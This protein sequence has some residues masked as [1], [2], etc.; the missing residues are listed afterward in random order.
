MDVPRIVS[1]WPFLNAVRSPLHVSFVQCSHDFA[2]RVDASSQHVKAL[3]GGSKKEH[4]SADAR[5]SSQPVH[6]MFLTGVIYP[7]AIASL[8]ELLCV[9]SKGIQ[10]MHKG[11]GFGVGA[12][13]GGGEG[14]RG[15]SAS[16]VENVN[17]S[18][19][20]TA[21]TGESHNLRNS[22][23]NNNNSN[24]KNSDTKNSNGNSSSS[25]AKSFSLK[26]F[27]RLDDSF[28]HSR[29]RSRIPGDASLEE[30]IGTKIGTGTKGQSDDASIVTALQPDDAHEPK[31][32]MIP[33]TFTSTLVDFSSSSRGAS[34][35]KGGLGT[36]SSRAQ[37]E[38]GAGRDRGDGDL[39]D[40]LE[41]SASKRI[42]GHPYFIVRASSSPK[43][44]SFCYYSA[45]PPS[46]SSS[47]STPLGAR[48]RNGSNVCGGVAIGDDTN[49]TAAAA[50]SRSA[51][52]R[53]NGSTHTAAPETETETLSAHSHYTE[54]RWSQSIAV[55]TPIV[56]QI[57]EK[58]SVVG[59]D[60]SGRK[61]KRPVPVVPS[62]HVE[63]IVDPDFY[64]E[65]LYGASA[66]LMCV[67]PARHSQTMSKEKREIELSGATLEQFNKYDIYTTETLIDRERGKAR[68][69]EKEREK[70]R[71]RIRAMKG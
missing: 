55:P 56:V 29:F 13:G 49:H 62:D 58:D 27:L 42:A 9:L 66:P 30:G 69:K 64:Y 8:T 11:A 44:E 40:R 37:G 26:K 70:E 50:I 7:D 31:M 47:S 24:N 22:N 21:D 61:R 60:S 15:S 16:S 20:G 1:K 43:M 57:I 25:S 67:M 51:A 52:D 45:F 34:S 32:P 68:E 35:S 4:S 14:V 17:G 12:G 33:M 54:I 19:L 18:R 3:T 5:S 53:C 59:V 38:S 2:E 63:G 71:E 46:S 41:W 6:R 65:I 39:R 28:L 36:G 10:P 23:G 48:E